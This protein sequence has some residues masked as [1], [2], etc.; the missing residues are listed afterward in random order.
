M[1]SQFNEYQWISLDVQIK[2]IFT[3]LVCWK[4]SGKINFNRSL[5]KKGYQTKM[6]EFCHLYSN[7][8]YLKLRR[9]SSI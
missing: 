4:G 3:T 2:Q 6:Q 7:N 1:Y 8:N 9:I 5:I